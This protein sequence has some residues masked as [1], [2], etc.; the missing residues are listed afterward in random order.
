MPHSVGFWTELLGHDKILEK[1]IEFLSSFLQLKLSK[2]ELSVS[3]PM[4]LS[5]LPL[6]LLYSLLKC[7][8]LLYNLPF[9]LLKLLYID[10]AAPRSLILKLFEYLQPLIECLHEL[11]SNFIGAFVV[12]LHLD[13]LL[14]HVDYWHTS[15]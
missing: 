12:S 10:L 11:V 13:Q 6:K 1:L 8:F 7:L 14:L 9:T 15:S 3:I 5:L 2:I 4:P